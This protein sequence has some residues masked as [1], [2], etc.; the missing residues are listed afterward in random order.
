LRY[1]PDEE[2][3][4]QVPKLS[5]REQQVLDALVEGLEYKEIGQR[6]SISTPTVKANVNALKIKFN[7]DNPISVVA[8][9]V[10]LGMCRP[11]FH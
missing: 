10:A 3:H 1:R 4:M 8:R 2:Q 5:I 6:L 9:A 11:K 7:A